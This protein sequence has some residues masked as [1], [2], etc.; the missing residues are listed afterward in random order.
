VPSPTGKKP[1]LFATAR[2]SICLHSS[3]ENSFRLCFAEPP[4]LNFTIECW[5]AANGFEDVVSI[6]KKL[7]LLSLMETI[8]HTTLAH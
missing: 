3:V 4:D 6:S 8:T 1:H 5:T 2:D 7:F